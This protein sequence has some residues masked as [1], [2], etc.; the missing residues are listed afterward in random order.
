MLRRV[1]ESWRAEVQ[2][3]LDSLEIVKTRT[4]NSK[5]ERAI[6][7]Q[8][9]RIRRE[10]LLS[11][12]TTRNFLPGH[13]FP[14]GVVS[15][16]TTTMEELERKRREPDREDNRA[17][18]SG[19]PARALPVAIRDYA[20][21]HRHSARWSGLSQRRG[22]LELAYTRGPGGTAGGTIS[23]LGMALPVLWC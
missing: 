8:L 17:V 14:T 4:S 23:A 1:A 22:D 6:N 7:L 9:E 11:E 5:P 20:P 18:R 15:L 16:V 2:A 3:L 21:R 12:L 13:G 19:Y 10:Y